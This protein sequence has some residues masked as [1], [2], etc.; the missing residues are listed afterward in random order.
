LKKAIFISFFLLFVLVAFAVEKPIFNGYIKYLPMLRVDRSFDQAYFDQL[1][2]N[3]VNVQWQIAKPLSFYASARTRIFQGYTVQNVP[4]YREFLEQDNGIVDMSK[5]L[6]RRNSWMMHTTS[7]R[8]YFDLQFNKWQIRVGRQRINWGINMVSNPNDLFNTYSFFDFDYEER[9]GT[10]A[11]RV[12]Y[13]AGAVSRFEAAFSP[14][15]DMKES[16]AA[17]L[18]SFNKKGYDFQ[19]ISGYFRNRMALGSG[20]A[21]HI[22][23]AGFK[24]EIT[25]FTDL[26]PV[27]GIQASNL[28]ASVSSDYLFNNGMYVLFEYLYNQQRDGVQT[29]ALFFTQPLSADNLSFSDHVLFAT[30]NY[31]V[32][33]I[34]STGMAS[35]Y[36]PTEG[37]VFFSPNI[38]WSI[39]KNLDFMFISQIFTG[40]RN[41][42]LSEAGYLFAT[43]VKWSF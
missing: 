3:R 6:F 22:K 21:G 4:F 37:A 39:R 31:P 10:D 28:V 41:S 8:M 33:P 26:E 7:D 13:F 38:N 19:F 23:K 35:F 43:S 15:R 18:Y 32:S 27:Q 12:Q 5:V 42:L 11:I 29:G 34:F 2:H 25:F 30:W 14:A 9:P 16:V 24:G 40:R 17:G 36:F 1:L 20:W